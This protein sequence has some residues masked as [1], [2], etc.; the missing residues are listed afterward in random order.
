[1]TRDISVD[2]PPHCVIW[3]HCRDTTP[4]S[5][6]YYLNGPYKYVRVCLNVFD[7]ERKYRDRPSYTPLPK[8]E[9]WQRD[10]MKLNINKWRQK[11]RE[12][13]EGIKSLSMDS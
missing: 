5:V 12:T 3:W 4:L 10:C 13:K 2:P 9:V 6:T 8:G 7:C 1:M 11:E